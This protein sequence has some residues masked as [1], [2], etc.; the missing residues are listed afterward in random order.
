M[1]ETVLS[2]S[3]RFQI[4]RTQAGTPA[5]PVIVKRVA[6]GTQGDAPWSELR[7]EA[8]ILQRLQAAPGCV[9]LV[10]VDAAQRQLVLQD[11]GG[12][13]WD[14][15]GL[16]GH[17]GLAQFLTLAEQL[18]EALATIHARGVTHKDI[19]PSTCWSNPSLQV[20]VIDFGLATTF[21]DEHPSL[22]TKS[23]IRGSWPSLTG[24]P[25]ATV[26][27][28]RPVP[29]CSGRA[30]LQMP[31][32]Q[33]IHRGALVAVSDLILDLLAKEP[34]CVQVPPAWLRTALYARNWPWAS[35]CGSAQ[36][37]SRCCSLW[38]W[39]L[40]KVGVGDSWCEIHTARFYRRQIRGL[41]QP[42]WAPAQVC[43][44]CALLWSKRPWLGRG[45]RRLYVVPECKLLGGS[46][47]AWA[48]V[49]H[50]PAG[51]W[52]LIGAVTAPN[53]LWLYSSLEWAA[54]SWTSSRLRQV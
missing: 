53:T 18:S 50:A 28:A 31:T 1:P 11:F 25:A 13:A 43:A 26:D 22:N 12:V 52:W 2:T 54:A 46:A 38:G 5:M 19:N 7:N 33:S 9:K 24:K 34:D 42:F 47:G 8:Q 29:G 30:A 51:C 27:T 15:S 35:G 17:V 32:A 3:E 44:G 48:M 21:T 39:V 4:V 6:Q 41:S 14:R 40:V 49:D 20:Q 23:K 10:Q 37:A 16:L 36:N 45:V